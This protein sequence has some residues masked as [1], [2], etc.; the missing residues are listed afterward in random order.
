MFKVQF[1]LNSAIKMIFVFKISNNFA[2]FY[3]F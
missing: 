2:F 1:K 3:E